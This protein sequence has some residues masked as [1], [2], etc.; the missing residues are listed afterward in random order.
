MGIISER[1]GINRWLNKRGHTQKAA[2]K[3]LS[4]YYQETGKSFW[5]THYSNRFFGKV[6]EQSQKRFNNFTNWYHKRQSL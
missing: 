5:R 4:E 1:I 3:I 6:Q 2:D